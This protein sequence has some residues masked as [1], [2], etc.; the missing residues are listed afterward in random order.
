MNKKKSKYRNIIISVFVVMISIMLGVFVYGH[1]RYQHI[2]INT[3]ARVKENKD[4]T[5]V[6]KDN[7]VL[8]VKDKNEGD[9]L[10][11]ALFGID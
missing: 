3:V 7:E 10:N 8:E 5:S 6:A 1:L 11:I 9:I 2:K 4:T